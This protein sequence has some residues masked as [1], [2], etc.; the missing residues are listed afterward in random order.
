MSENLIIA[1]NTFIMNYYENQ[2][3]DIDFNGN[4]YLL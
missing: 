1:V 2:T 4:S 3:P